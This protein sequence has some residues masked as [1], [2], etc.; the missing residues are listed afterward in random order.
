MIVKVQALP[1]NNI[2]SYN[3][4]VYYDGGE[5][6]FAS[7]ADDLLVDDENLL[8]DPEEILVVE[9]EKVLVL[10]RKYVMIYTARKKR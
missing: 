9:A 3:V 7:T 5:E 1:P 4:T 6:V 10:P 2:A 8:L